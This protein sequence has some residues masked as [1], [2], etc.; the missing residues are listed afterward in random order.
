[1]EAVMG[2]AWDPLGELSKFRSLEHI[3][4]QDDGL[5]MFEC[6]LVHC[7]REGTSTVTLLDH[8]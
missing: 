3:S 4:I 7:K 1:M 5:V 8:L 2:L 6:D